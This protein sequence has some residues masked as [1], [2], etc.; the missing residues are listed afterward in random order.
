MAAYSLPAAVPRMPK[1]RTPSSKLRNTAQQPQQDSNRG[2]DNGTDSS[3]SRAV[4]GP[5]TSTS[6][7]AVPVL[8]SSGGAG[9]GSRQEQKLGVT[10]SDLI[11]IAADGHENDKV[12][13]AEEVIDARRLPAGALVAAVLPSR[14]KGPNASAGP[15]I[16]VAAGATLSGV[17]FLPAERECGED[18]RSLVWQSNAEEAGFDDGSA[19]GSGPGDESDEPMSPR[20][21]GMR[22][23]MPDSGSQQA[24]ALMW[25]ERPS[26]QLLDVSR[27]GRAEIVEEVLLSRRHR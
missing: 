20:V 4:V 8:S 26:F 5:E 24:V 3:S 12:E 15:G 17:S 6:L 2:G 10:M 11:S 19:A 21:L 16:L 1:S 14:L 18:H 7:S 22:S 9:D 23:I 25:A 27:G 13:E